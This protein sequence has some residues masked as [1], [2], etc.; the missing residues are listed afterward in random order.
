MIDTRQRIL[1][2]LVIALVAAWPSGRAAAEPLTVDRAVELALRGSPTLRAALLDLRAAGEALRAAEAEH[3]PTLRAGVDGGHNES[4]GSTLEGITPNSSD[5]VGLEVGVSYGARWGTEVSLSVG[6]D[7]QTREVNRDPSTTKNLAIGPSYGVDATLEVRQPL[8]RGAGRDVGEA[9]IRSAKLSVSAA[10]HA[11][12]RTASELLR[13]VL[14]AYWE[15]WYARTAVEVQRASR[16][17][18]E[19]QLAEAEARVEQLGTV[20]RADALRYA[21]ELAFIE[22]ALAEAELTRLSRAIELGRLLG[23]APAEARALGVASDPPGPSE[24]PPLEVVVA[25]ASRESSELLELSAEVELAQDQIR[26]ARD[27]TLPRLDLTGSLAVGALWDDE[28]IGTG[29]LPGD[30][31]AISGLAGLELELPLGNAEARASLAEARSR[32]EAAEARLEARR[33]AI[34]AEVAALVAQ[35]EIADRRVA[36]A[37]RSAEIAGQLAEAERE[38]L[39]LGTSTSFQVLEAQENQ[40]ET[41]LRYARAL[42][43]R[44]AAELSLRHLTGAL[45]ERYAELVEER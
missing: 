44:A 19:R 41:E 11:R 17:L 16:E 36:L 31:P 18:A 10:E 5:R 3:L 32:A 33:Q 21:S 13:D 28:T 14:L 15:L 1:A 2:P 38:R 24:I 35:H 25:L 22:E 39:R 30:R 43:D 34:A 9:P 29:E 23:L 27:A 37:R 4:F 12:D 6:G 8:L 42:V 26:A 7:W 45:L 20:A 40:R